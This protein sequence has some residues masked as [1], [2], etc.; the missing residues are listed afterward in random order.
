MEQKIIRADGN[1]KELMEWLR[2]KKPILVCDGSIDFLTDLNRNLEERGEEIIR[3]SDFQPN[4]LYESVV[5]GVKIFHREN[6][7]SIIAVGGGSAIDVAKCIK[8]YSNMDGDG[9]DG[10]YLKQ[11]IAENNI[12]FWLCQL[13]PEQDQRQ[14]NM[15][16]FII[17]ERNKV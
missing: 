3:F 7:D 16:L 11:E 1:Y 6:C 5:E 17:M 8:L 14:R 12:P 13:P 10:N 15:P 4:P 2:N 9:A